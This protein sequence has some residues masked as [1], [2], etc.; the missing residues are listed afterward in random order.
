MILYIGPGAGFVFGGTF[1]AIL[2]AIFSG[3]VSLLL[4]PIRLV[5]RTLSGAK[6]YRD[7]KVKRV[8]YLGLDGFDPKLADGMVSHVLDPL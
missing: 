8:V 2:A 5:R 4:W 1:I 6:A 7:A 3:L